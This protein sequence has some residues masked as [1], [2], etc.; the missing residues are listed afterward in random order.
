MPECP[1]C[2][3]FS[4][5]YDTIRKRARCLYAHD[6]GYAG[7]IDSLPTRDDFSVEFGYGRR[8]VGTPNNGNGNYPFRSHSTLQY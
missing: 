6:C 8:R 2:H 7:E 3:R 4:L 5:E 1:Q